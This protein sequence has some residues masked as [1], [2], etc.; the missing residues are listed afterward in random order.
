MKPRLLQ[1]PPSQLVFQEF[2][3]G[4]S[5]VW[6]LTERRSPTLSDRMVTQNNYRHTRD[7]RMK[8]TQGK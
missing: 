6:G 2:Q 1:K 5:V 8:R 3:I 7:I 4:I